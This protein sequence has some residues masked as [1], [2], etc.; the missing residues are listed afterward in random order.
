MTQNQ[1]IDI[2]SNANYVRFSIYKR[3]DIPRIN[4]CTNGNQALQDTL[5]QDAEYNTEG[6]QI[7]G[8]K[9]MDDYKQAEENILESLDFSAV[10]DLDITINAN[11]SNFIWQIVDRL[12]QIN[13]KII[14]LF[15]S[16]LGLGLV[17]LILNR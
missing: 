15:T 8:K 7:E 6:E 17:K 13:S 12:R 1:L 9:E 14:L 10:D 11:A 5:D 3:D 16:V 2:P 4:Y